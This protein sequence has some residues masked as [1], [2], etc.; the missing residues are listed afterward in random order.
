[1][2]S[3]AADLRLLFRQ[4][5]LYTISRHAEPTP[6]PVL[7]KAATKMAAHRRRALSFRPRHISDMRCGYA[8]VRLLLG[9]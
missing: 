2:G 9:H 1:M 3:F 5:F 8:Q 6:I 4:P 7:Y